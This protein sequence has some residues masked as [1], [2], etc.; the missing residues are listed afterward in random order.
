M[1]F[2]VLIRL[3][4]FLLLV[5]PQPA[6]AAVTNRTIDDEFGDSITGRPPYY[7]S[8]GWNYGP[9]C[10][11]C[12]A[13]PAPEDVFMGSWHD[14][15]ST[16]PSDGP[17]HTVSITFN[18][19]A[20]WVYCIVPN[21]IPHTTTFVNISISL[22]GEVVGSYA[23]EADT[24]SEAYIYNVTVYS[25]T[26]LTNTQHVVTLTAMQDPDA[27][28]LLFDWAEYTHDDDDD[29]K[30]TTLTI[31]ATS[32]IVP[33]SRSTEHEIASSSSPPASASSKAAVPSASGKAQ[34]GS[35]ASRWK[36]IL[37][38]CL[39]G[40]GGASAIGVLAA[41]LLFRRRRLRQCHGVG[42][43]IDSEPLVRIPRVEPF[44]EQ[45]SAN[46]H[47]SLLPAR[48]HGTTHERLPSTSTM[49]QESLSDESQRGTLSVTAPATFG[50][51]NQEAAQPDALEIEREQARLV[52]Q[53]RKIREH[54]EN[55]PHR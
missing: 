40:G 37:V 43:S 50:T 42:G 10:P 32:T 36:V 19:T 24:K 45:P 6:P 31:T 15:T 21:N 47:V 51:S 35:D 25:N 18:G 22:D 2:V 33:S 7:G 13:Q 12:K 39:V 28:M 23:H 4:L 46:Q 41:A 16:T 3:I 44:M 5:A 52:R 30:M 53:V 1:S 11:G 38:G 54:M 49:L 20:V 27:S 34:G 14:T 48:V 17:A 29:E 8:S 55:L 26:H 9:S